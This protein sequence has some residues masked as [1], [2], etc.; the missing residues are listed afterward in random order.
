[1]LRLEGEPQKSKKL[2]TPRKVNI[3]TASGAL[4]TEATKRELGR[5]CRRSWAYVGFEILSL[6]LQ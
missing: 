1:M 2:L 5:G 6:I 3:T 4:G